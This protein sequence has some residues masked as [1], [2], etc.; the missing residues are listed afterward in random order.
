MRCVSCL[1]EPGNRGRPPLQHRTFFGW[2][3]GLA[4]LLFCY[5]GTRDRAPSNSG[6]L[7]THSW[8]H[9]CRQGSSDGG[10]RLPYEEDDLYRFEAPRVF[11]ACKAAILGMLRV[12]VRRPSRIFMKLHVDWGPASARQLEQASAYSDGDNMNSA[13]Y[14]DE[15]LDSVGC[16]GIP[17]KARMRLS[18]RPQLYRRSLGR[19]KLPYGSQVISWASRF[20]DTR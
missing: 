8:C 5:W 14:L 17:T 3:Y 18:R 12:A 4:S 1:S 9:F 13:N 6:A 15:A 11:S 19:C 2:V 7:R 10:I 16:V 20:M